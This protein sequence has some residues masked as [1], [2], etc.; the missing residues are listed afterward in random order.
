LEYV[1]YLAAQIIMPT[2][3]AP[4]QVHVPADHAQHVLWMTHQTPWYRIARVTIT[5]M[6]SQQLA[7]NKSRALMITLTSV[8]LLRP[9]TQVAFAR[10]RLA[11]PILTVDLPCVIQIPNYVLHV[12]TTV[13]AEK[14]M[15]HDTVTWMTAT[16]MKL[17]ALPFLKKQLPLPPIVRTV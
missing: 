14:P 11:H 7:T 16:A 9:V 17:P 2:R 8:P 4:K 12:L 10:N 3:T 15:I 1:K 6:F 5:A 13:A